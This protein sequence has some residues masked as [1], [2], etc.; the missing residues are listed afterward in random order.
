M[1]PG[2]AEGFPGIPKSW[3][4]EAD[5]KGTVNQMVQTHSCP[6]A[7]QIIVEVLKKISRNDFVKCF[8]ESGSEHTKS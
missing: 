4:E 1:T 6:G 3:L 2:I 7:L 8:S 5:R